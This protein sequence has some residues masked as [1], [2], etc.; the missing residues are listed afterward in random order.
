MD[1][2]A[3]YEVVNLLT[4]LSLLAMILGRSK[5]EKMRQLAF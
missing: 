1:L 5:K 2:K 3:E 4:L